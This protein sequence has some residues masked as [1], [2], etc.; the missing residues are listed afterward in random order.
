MNHSRQSITSLLACGV[1]ISTASLVAQTPV[2]SNAILLAM[3]T[4]TKQLLQYEWK[5]RITVVRKGNPTQPVIDQIR[6]GADGQMQR[7]TISA[8][9]QKEISRE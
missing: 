8:P 4:N 3:A 6:F 5:Q 9:E 7:T 2:T 1:L